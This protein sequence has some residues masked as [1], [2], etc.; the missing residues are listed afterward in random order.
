M[1]RSRPLFLAVNVFGTYQLRLRDLDLFSAALTERE[2]APLIPFMA[3][4]ALLFDFDQ[5]RVAIAIKSEVLHRLR[6]AAR[7]AFH[8]EFLP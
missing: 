5:Q 7:L 2:K 6:V 8:P 3:G 4:S 1:E